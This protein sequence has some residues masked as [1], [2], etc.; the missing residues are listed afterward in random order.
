MVMSPLTLADLKT[1]RSLHLSYFLSVYLPLT[2]PLSD[3]HSSVCLLSVF[4]SVVFLSVYLSIFPILC[5]TFRIFD[6]HLFVCFL[7]LFPSIVSVFLSFYQSTFSFL[8]KM[9]MGP[10]GSFIVFSLQLLFLH[11]YYSR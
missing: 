7:S 11:R 10:K 6:Y 1:E 9:I 3:F 8:S 4:S 2:F 5:I